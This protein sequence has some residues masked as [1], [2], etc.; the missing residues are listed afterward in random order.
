MIL[1]NSANFENGGVYYYSERG[2]RLIDV[3]AFHEKLLQVMCSI[4]CVLVLFIVSNIDV[5][6]N[7]FFL[8]LRFHKN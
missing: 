4:L 6:F 5:M 2:G 8:L 3:D 1:R 7:E